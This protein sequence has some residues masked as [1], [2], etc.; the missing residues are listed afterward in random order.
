MEH[1]PKRNVWVEKITQ[2]IL[3]IILIVSLLIILNMVKDS[4]ASEIT[5]LIKEQ[6]Q[7]ENVVGY[8]IMGCEIA[9][10]FVIGT[11]AV[12]AIINYVMRMFDRSLSKQI[13]TAE[14]IRLRLGHQLS[15]GLE[16]AV[17]SDILRLTVSPSPN[18][19]LLLFAI[20]LLR[21]LLNYFLEYDI[22]AIAD[23]NLLC[24]TEA[25]ESDARKDV[26]ENLR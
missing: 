7:L 8:V 10:V 17:A 15:L 12:I 22:Q 11:S 20:I 18:D 9:A 6:E 16:F 14:S 26:L 19:I 25:E 13:K 23:Y 4:P 21:I 1:Y 24:D 2:Y 5:A 3:P